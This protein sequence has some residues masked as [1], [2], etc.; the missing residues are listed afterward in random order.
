LIYFPSRDMIAPATAGLA[1]TEEVTFSAAD[2]PTLH[3]WF[4]PSASAPPRFTVIVFNG[5]AGNRSHR[6]DLA[7]AFRAQDLSVLLFD[8]RGYG[9]ND[10]APSESGLAADAR[11]ARAYVA[12]RRDVDPKRVIYFGESL[13]SAVATKLAS[14]HPPAALVLRS[15]FNTIAEVGRI[16]YPW[17]PVSWLLRDRFA[18]AEHIQRIRSPL[19]VIAG[20][21]DTIVPFAQSQRLYEAA[22]QPKTLVVIKG[23]DHNDEALLA[24][25]EMVRALDR[26]L[27]GIPDP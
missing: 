3:A 15:P 14:E 26:F 1:G 9:D 17:L 22:A 12:A 25:A 19:L 24:G 4:V 5:N 2:T 20:D 23:A 8:Y 16:H 27:R 13:G 11:A 21:R 6:S 7:R 18:P 10:G